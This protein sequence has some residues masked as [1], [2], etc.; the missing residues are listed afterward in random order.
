MLKDGT[1]G[2]KLIYPLL[3]SKWDNRT[4]VALPDS[5]IFYL[6]ALLRSV[7]AGPLVEKSVAQNNE[8]VEW[9]IRQGLDSKQYFPRYQSKEDWKRHF[10]NQWTRFVERKTSFDP[11][12]ILAPGQKIFKRT[13]RS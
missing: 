7:P 6:V 8:I 4:S 2:P 9:C 10:G 12:T 5:E 3:R 1:G 13:H 11:M